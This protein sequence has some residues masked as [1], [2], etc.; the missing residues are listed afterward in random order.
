MLGNS[1]W[2]HGGYCDEDVI[3]ITLQVSMMTLS[4]LVLAALPKAS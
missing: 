3:Q 4:A 1:Y 2:L